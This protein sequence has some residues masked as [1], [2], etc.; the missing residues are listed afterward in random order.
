MGVSEAGDGNAGIE[1]EIGA[2]IE[3][4]QSRAPAARDGE[5]REQRDRLHARRDEFLLFI[6]ELFRPRWRR[7]LGLS[8]NGHVW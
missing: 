7:S 4:D 6:E 2:A 1:I 5:F 8:W 3:V